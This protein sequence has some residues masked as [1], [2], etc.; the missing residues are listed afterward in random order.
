M[1][2]QNSWRNKTS[3]RH[4]GELLEKY[5]LKNKQKKPKTMRWGVLTSAMEF[6]EISQ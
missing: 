1:S 6:R 3:L 2:A 4:L 5:Y